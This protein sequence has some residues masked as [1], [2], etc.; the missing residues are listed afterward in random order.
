MKTSPL[1]R[2]YAKALLELADEQNLTSR[3]RKDLEDLAATW[4]SSAELRGVFE[5]PAVTLEP[6]RKVVEALATRMGM[7]KLT[8]NTLK[9]LSD[10]GRFAF[11]PEIADAFADLADAQTGGLRAE[12]TS[13]SPMP[14]SYYTRLKAELEK[15]TGRK[16][17][18]VKKQDPAL[19]AGV[20]TRVGDKI[21]DGS[22][23]HRLERL[24]E[25]LM[26]P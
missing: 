13:A 5:N 12:V 2:R 1:S 14:E 16:V 25:E 22:V 11:V 24:Q 17:T 19:I 6:R 23:Q 7:Q 3:V 21:Y 15:A 8:A 20:V 9:L 26:A 4:N 18:L 10:G